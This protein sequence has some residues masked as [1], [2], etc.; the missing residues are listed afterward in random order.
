MNP[1]VLLILDF[2]Q[3]PLFRFAFALMALGLLRRA[4][5]GMSDMVGAYVTAGQR[6]FF[7]RRLGARI[8]WFF[9]PH[10]L[11]RNTPYSRGGAGLFLYHSVLFIV[12]LL[13]R[14]GAVLVPAFMAAHV[15]LWKRGFGVSWPSL[16]T[17][18]A[19]VLT[20]ATITAGSVLFLG[21][22]YSPMLRAVE[23]AWS[24]VQPLLLI[25]PFVTGWLSRHPTYSPFDYPVIMLL[26]VLSAVVVLLLIPFARMFSAIHVPIV[27]LLPEMQWRGLEAEPTAKAAPGDVAP[28]RPA[29]AT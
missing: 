29:A 27:G 28:N 6:Q 23:P 14:L 22:L 11:L 24:F 10:V 8:L 20:V 19:D 21:R 5:L 26:H 12:S 2:A 13:F 16:P 9:F 3:G 25:L 15:Y 7:R 17:T 4:F 18:V 1:T